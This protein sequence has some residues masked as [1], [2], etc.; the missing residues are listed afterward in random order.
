MLQT[1]HLRLRHSSI[2][3][4][5]QHYFCTTLLRHEGAFM[6][7]KIY[8]DEDSYHSLKRAVPRSSRSRTVLESVERASFFNIVITCGEAEARNLLLYADH[9][10][11]AVES[12]E[13][14][15]RVAEIGDKKND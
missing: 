2:T 14:A 5:G 6:S 9:C 11:R 15:L 12:I 13:K 1:G 4:T 10:P 7:L 3:S 8:L